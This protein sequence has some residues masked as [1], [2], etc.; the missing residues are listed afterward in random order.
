MEERAGGEE[1]IYPIFLISLGKYKI[2]DKSFSIS[3]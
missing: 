3:L 1:A 2:H